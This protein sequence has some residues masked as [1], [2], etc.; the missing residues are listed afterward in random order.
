MG[1]K[2]TTFP[3]QTGCCWEEKPMVKIKDFWDWSVDFSSLI[4]WLDLI[5][6]NVSLEYWRHS[7]THKTN[8]CVHHKL[9]SSWMIHGYVICNCVLWSNPRTDWWGLSDLDKLVR[10]NPMKKRPLRRREDKA[11]GT[12]WQWTGKN[13]GRMT[14]KE[15]SCL[16]E[17]YFLALLGNIHLFKILCFNW[18]LFLTGWLT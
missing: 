5:L 13:S 17:S 3:L 1:K 7:R 14:W 6:L 11:N 9:L 2:Y 18:G 8:S 4:I 15:C 12:R 10:S 16:W